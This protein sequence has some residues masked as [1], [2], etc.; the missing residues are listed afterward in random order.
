MAELIGD[1]TR[2]IFKESPGSLTFEVQDVPAICQRRPRA[3]LVTLLDKY[4]GNAGPVPALASG[5]DL[6]IL[7]C[8]K[9]VVAI[10]T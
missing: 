3:G 4:M 7:A 2:A 1:R 5:I 6:A 8:T 9:Y 10:R